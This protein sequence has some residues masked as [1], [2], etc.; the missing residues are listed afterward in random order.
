[1][2]PL[3]SR[4]AVAQK[5]RTSPRAAI[6]CDVAVASGVAPGRHA[7]SGWEQIIGRMDRKAPADI[8][9]GPLKDVGRP[10][11]PAARGADSSRRAISCQGELIRPQTL[12]N[13]ANRAAAR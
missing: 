3:D 4:A 7:N 2:Q 10:W 5:T 8:R 12:Y 1:M 9:G 13:P 11:F 6:Q